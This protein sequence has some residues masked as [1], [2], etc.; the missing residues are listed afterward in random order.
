MLWF[1]ICEVAMRGN[2]ESD[3]SMNP[4]NWITFIK[5]QLETNPIFKDLHNKFAKSR[6][7][8]YTT[9]TSVNG[10]IEVIAET[11]PTLTCSQIKNVGVFSALNISMTILLDSDWLRGVQLFH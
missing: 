4:G 6:S 1:T 2:D 9:K 11:I 3:D 10:F 7:T 5:L 8:D